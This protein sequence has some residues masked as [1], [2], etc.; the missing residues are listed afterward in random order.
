LITILIFTISSCSNLLRKNEV[1]SKSLLESYSAA[2]TTGDAG[3]W[4]GG[5][6]CPK[7]YLSTNAAGDIDQGPAKIQGKNFVDANNSENRDGLVLEFV[8]SFAPTLEFTNVATLISGKKYYIPWRNII[9]E[10]SFTNP[11]LSN[12]YVRGHI[13]TDK[14]ISY[15]LT[16]Y[17]PFAYMSTPVSDDNGNAITKRINEKANQVRDTIKVSKEVINM[18]F[19]EYKTAKENILRINVGAQNLNK[20]I[21][22]VQKNIKTVALENQARKKTL[23]MLTKQYAVDSIKVEALKNQIDKNNDEIIQSNSGIKAMTDSIDTL[24]KSKDD[25]KAQLTRATKKSDGLIVAAAS[26][27]IVLD[28]LAPEMLPTIKLSKQGFIDLKEN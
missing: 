26:K 22:K 28:T 9:P 25:P 18:T 21:D 6:N 20:E 1:T 17:F 19:P 2:E 15:Q 7:I 13:R 3:T 10:F 23:E 14:D 16:I 8:N 24:T 4:E 12:K 11:T 5:F 27:F